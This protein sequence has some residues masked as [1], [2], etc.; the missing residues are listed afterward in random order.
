MLTDDGGLEREAIM[1]SECPNCRRLFCAGCKVPWHSEIGEFQKVNKDE[2]DREDI[3][4]M[5]LAKT[6]MWMR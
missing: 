6:K 4:L 2:R 3:M 1:Q 5:H